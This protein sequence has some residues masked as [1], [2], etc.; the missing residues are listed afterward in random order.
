MELERDDVDYRTLTGSV[1]PRPIAWVS[2]RSPDGVDNLAP[3]SFFNV[4]SIT[5][6]VLFFSPTKYD[7]RKPD[8]F[9]DTPRNVR[10]SGEFVVNV[11][12]EPLLERMNETSARLPTGESE[13][14]SAGIDRAESTLVSPPRVAAADIAFECTLYEQIQIGRSA[15]TF[16]EV[17]HAYVDDA[18]LTDEGALD[19]TLLDA[20][21]RL[22]GGYY[23]KLN[24][25][26]YV[27]LERPP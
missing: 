10:T 27:Y 13:F 9:K 25:D 20:V 18:L 21:G 11:V 15:P 24:R 2:S 7:R 19:V 22:A 4:A 17:V 16:G 26:D 5:P 23:A 14:D 12:T 6:P 1:V 3:F 8:R